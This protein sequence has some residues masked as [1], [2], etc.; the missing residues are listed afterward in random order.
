MKRQQLASCLALNYG[1]FTRVFLLLKWVKSCIVL[2]HQSN[3]MVT[4]KLY[5]KESLSLSVCYWHILRIAPP[6]YSTLGQFVAEDPRK[7]SVKFH[8]VRTCNMFCINTFWMVGCCFSGFMALQT[9]V[10]ETDV[11]KMEISVVQHIAVHLKKIRWLK[12]QYTCFR[13]IL[14]LNDILV[15]NI[16]KLAKMIKIMSISRSSDVKRSMFFLFWFFCCRYIYWS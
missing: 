5:C 3:R 7:N 14:P 16:Q 15:E 12:R 8:E 1:G 9:E 2:L 10:L 13:F 11:N 4:I 6:I